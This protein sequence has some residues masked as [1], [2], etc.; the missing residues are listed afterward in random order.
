MLP[1]LRDHDL[2]AADKALSAA[3][4]ALLGHFER[5]LL[6]PGG[7]CHSEIAVLLLRSELAQVSLKDAILARQSEM[8]LGAQEALGG[9]RGVASAA[10]LAERAPVAAS[11]IGFSRILFSR[12]RDGTWFPYSACAGE[13]EEFA[14]AMVR[15]GTDNPRR[16]NGPLLESE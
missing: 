9:L 14:Q 1:S 12:I 15:A 4:R 16:L 8:V 13:D 7:K 3:R 11:R 5:S 10:S 2:E 6:S